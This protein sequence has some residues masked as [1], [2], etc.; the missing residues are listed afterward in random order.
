MGVIEAVLLR[1][2]IAQFKSDSP[3]DFTGAAS[4]PAF[5]KK[6]AVIDFLDG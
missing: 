3:D 2:K 5:Q 1:E 4:A 6:G